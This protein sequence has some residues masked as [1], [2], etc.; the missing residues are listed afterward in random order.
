MKIWGL[1]IVVNY[2]MQICKYTTQWYMHMGMFTVCTL[3]R[4][5]SDTFVI[6]YTFHLQFRHSFV[7]KSFECPYETGAGQSVPFGTLWESTLFNLSCGQLSQFRTGFNTNSATCC[8]WSRPPLLQGMRPQA[9]RWCSSSGALM[10]L[11]FCRRFRH[12]DLWVVF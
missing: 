7:W 5:V 12:C 1:I 6:I 9:I 4:R 8:T 11:I 2:S 10:W 3:G